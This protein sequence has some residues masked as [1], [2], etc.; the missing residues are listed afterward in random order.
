MS[1]TWKGWEVLCAAIGC[2]SLNGI[3]WKDFVMRCKL[4]DAT[5]AYFQ[6]PSM[7]RSVGACLGKLSRPS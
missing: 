2:L 7:I 4:D 3:V 1:L 6:W 5:L